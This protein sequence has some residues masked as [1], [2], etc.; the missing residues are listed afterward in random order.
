MQDLSK[1]VVGYIRARSLVRAGDRVCVAVSGGADSVALLRLLLDLRSELGIV[2]SVAHLNH[3]LR[4][5]ESRADAAFVAALASQHKLEL[6]AASEDVAGFAKEHS[7]SLETAGR[8]LRY[9]FFSSLLRDGKATRVATAHTADD[10]AETVMFRLLRGAG[11][12]GLAG[13]L[14][15]R[16][17]RAAQPPSAEQLARSAETNRIIRPLLST[18]RG[19]LRRH[20][21]EIGQ[22]WREDASNLDLGFA[23]NRLRAAL[24]PL[25]ERDYNPGLVG[26]LTATAEI[27]R[28]EEEYW[29]AELARLLPAV[30]TSAGRL[31]TAELSRQPLAVQR[32]LIRLA[33]GPVG[34]HPVEQVLDLL[35]R[36]GR[37]ERSLPL[38]NCQVARLA[39]GE[40]WFE[41]ASGRHAQPAVYNYRL[42]I[43]GEVCIRELQRRITA[44]VLT[45]PAAAAGYNPQQFLDPSALASELSVRNWRAGD[46]FRPLHSKAPR[47]LKELLQRVPARERSTWPVVV[48][49]DEIV[50]VRGLAVSHDRV[51]HSTSQVLVIRESSL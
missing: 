16:D 20:L 14:P 30:L 43:P 27:A 17:V 11:T 28:A 51:A 35:R 12:R 45:V 49:G 40:L 37:A 44:S 1:S 18:R 10:Q 19:D 9:Q 24:L 26:A 13:I 3:N 23:R 33:G 38:P 41:A 2:L 25:L 31:R 15:S 39:A 5:T 32:R 34:F 6:H 7:L 8:Q 36:G 46:R 21:R 29:N 4:G 47:K 48:S 22:P 42:K 50:W